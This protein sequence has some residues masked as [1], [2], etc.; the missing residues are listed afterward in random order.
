[1]RGPQWKIFSSFFGQKL[2]WEVE[3]RLRYQS[4]SAKKGPF[5][6]KLVK[7]DIFQYLLHWGNSKSVHKAFSAKSQG[8]YFLGSSYFFSGQPIGIK[9]SVVR[10]HTL[11]L[12]PRRTICIQKKH[13][14]MLSAKS[15]VPIGFQEKSNLKN[16][17]DHVRPKS[18]QVSTDFQFRRVLSNTSL[19]FIGSVAWNMKNLFRLV[20]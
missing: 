19:N 8:L 14:N 1:M 4:C 16:L 7:H 13:I 12:L 3:I 9:L 6:M 10:L 15:L 20:N 5:L 17:K 18:R 11:R 2:Q